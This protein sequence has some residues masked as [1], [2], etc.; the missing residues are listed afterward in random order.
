M[1]ERIKLV[2]LDW[3]GTTIDHGC[4]GPVQPFVE[5]LKR[6]GVTVSAADVRGPMGIDKKEHLRALLALP[7]A[8]KQWADHHG[9]AELEDGDVDR[10][11]EEM[12]PLAVESVKAHTQ[13]I[14]GVREMASELRRRGL[15]IGA[16]TGYFA[17][18]AEACHQAAA[19]QGYRPDAAFCASDVTA[20]RPAPFMIHRNM[21]ATGVYPAGSVLKIGDTVPDIEEG[22]N[23]GCWS[24]GVVLT[25]SEMGLTPA[26]LEKLPAS[27]RARRTDAIREKLLDA[28]A[29]DVIDSVRDV[30]ALIDDINARIAAGERP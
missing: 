24:V 18:A 3:A 12:K 30:P 17:E 7:H 11:F 29:H 10:L 19:E 26:E 14:D 25:G 22:L 28:G 1:I 21:D 9:G 4:F 13:L 16:S 5:V 8:A 27:E 20:G 2:V 6:N 23:A 15:K